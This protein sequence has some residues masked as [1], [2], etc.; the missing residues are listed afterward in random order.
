MEKDCTVNPRKIIPHQHMW[1]YESG[2]KFDT[3]GYGARYR[4]CSTCAKRQMFDDFL[5]EYVD[6][7]PK[8]D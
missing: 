2:G 4:E 1:Q 8:V 5:V 6:I 7:N 3:T